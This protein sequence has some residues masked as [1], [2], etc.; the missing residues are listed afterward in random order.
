MSIEILNRRLEPQYD[1]FLR[2]QKSSTIYYTLKYRDLISRETS[3]N[4]LYLVSKKNDKINGIFPLM[5]KDGPLGKI[6]NSLP[7]FGS[8][9]GII[10]ADKK[11]TNEFIT[12]Y[13]ELLSANNYAASVIIENPFLKKIDYDQIKYNETDQRVS[14]TSDISGRYQ[15]L[16]DLLRLFHS[17]TRNSIRKAI[18]SNIEVSINNNAWDFIYNTHLNNMKR[19]EGK[20]KKRSFFNLFKSIMKSEKD[21]NIYV[22]KLNNEMIA[23]LLIIYHGK[24][25]EYFTPVVKS[26][27]RDLQPLSLII[28]KAMMDSSAGGFNCWNWGGTWL[29]QDGVN[30]FKSRWGTSNKL[31]NYYISIMNKEIYNASK[32]YLMKHYDGFYVIP[33]NII[34]N[35]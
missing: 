19:L 32:E 12:Y 18:K 10:A 34:Q 23:A 27:F 6:I 7:Y 3:S 22:A 9:G 28:A 25:V 26:E 14:Q 31:Y 5:I 16:N 15:E 20:A 8:H 30:R 35:K 4:P 17:K 33:F 21:F 29:N 11:V 2:S 1:E 13:N 24:T